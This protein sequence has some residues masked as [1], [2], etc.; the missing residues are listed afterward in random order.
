VRTEQDDVRNDRRI[1][2]QARDERA[3]A[4]VEF[5]LVFPFVVFAMLAFISIASVIIQ[6]EHLNAAARE[7]ARFAARSQSTSEAIR[8][9]AL[10]AMPAGRF[11]GTPTVEV[12]RF[13][14]GAT[15]WIGPLGPAERPCN[16]V[17]IGE[18]RV[19]V[20]VSGVVRPDM[21][22]VDRATL[23]LSAQGVYRCE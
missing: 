8:M 4:A 1:L 6:F 7:S 2:E 10:D 14:P 18:S 3:A 17:S 23:A 13:P 22:L 16:Q 21:P 9:R 20:R 11:V 12:H 19:R 5:A 15:D